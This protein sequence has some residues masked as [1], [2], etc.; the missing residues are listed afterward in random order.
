MTG[1]ATT[2]TTWHGNQS[3][4]FNATD[5][6]AGV[7]RLVVQSG[8]NSGS[9]IT[10]STDIINS[11]SG[12]CA[13]VPGGDGAY[14]FYY[15]QPCSTS[16]SPT[17]A[18]DSSQLP[19][20]SQFVRV[21]VEDAAGNR[22]TAYEG[23]KTVDN[24]AP[25]M[26]LDLTGGNQIGQDLHCNATVTGQNPTVTYTWQRANADGSNVQIIAGETSSTY[27]LTA[28][29]LGKKVQCTATATDQGGS[30]S[31][32]SLLTSG[33]FASGGVV[34]IAAPTVGQATVT[35]QPVDG[36]TVTCDGVVT[37]TGVTTTIQWVRTEAD[38]SG[39]VVIPGATQ[40]DYTLTPADVGKRL[41]CSISA[42]NT[43]GSASS[44]S[45]PTS[46]VS[47][48]APTVSPVTTS[49]N[50]YSGQVLT[51]VGAVT[52]VNATTTIQWLRTDSNGD[53]AVVIDGQSGRTYTLT[54]ADV[55][56][57]VK[58][59]ITGTNSG[60]SASETSDPTV[61]ITANV[62][63]SDPN[64]P[65]SNPDTN[66]PG[67][68]IDLAANDKNVVPVV[69]PD[70]A[71]G[72][73][74]NPA[75]PLAVLS[76]NFQ[77]NVGSSKRTVTAATSKFSQRLRIRGKIHTA[78]GKPIVGAKLYLAQTTGKKDSNGNAVWKI[79]GGTISRNDGT[80]LMFSTAAGK[81]RQI[82]LVY[83]PYGGRVANRGSNILGLKVRQDASLKLSKQHLHNNQTLK[84]MGKVRGIVSRKTVVQVQVR[85]PAGWTTFKNTHPKSS[86]A[87]SAKWT[88]RKTTKRTTYRFRVRVRP[89]QGSGYVSSIS[90]AHKAVVTR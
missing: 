9:L 64:K 7:Y 74:G 48:A 10:R 52:G 66:D 45:D 32:T 61:L 31:L 82:R 29:D 36:Q 68:V 75:D 27:T 34:V 43:S 50:T 62:D 84:F 79:N 42:Q 33:P 13:P 11:N 18:I 47:L 21:S 72:D 24:Q 8:A 65:P 55:G 58:C 53:G 85:L 83:F 28:A 51:C 71:K 22:T 4:T 59:K 25:T 3:M 40:R 2:G 16:L 67:T 54:A 19:E 57:R 38:G 14:S 30:A 76:V 17:V 86:G 73:N 77:L 70:T 88:F 89:A 15:A 23:T 37:G 39:P 1:D 35:G 6:G 80:I 69:N 41:K 90:S 56:K 20:G 87:F 26:A 44:T 78:D 49:G 5:S 63:G 46:V 60:G 81:N 12:R